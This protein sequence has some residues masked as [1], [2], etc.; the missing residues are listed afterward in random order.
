MKFFSGDN[1]AAVVAEVATV[2]HDV[3]AVGDEHSVFR[4]ILYRKIFECNIFH[5]SSA[6]WPEHNSF[7]AG[8]VHVHAVA[9]V[10]VRVAIFDGI[11][12]AL[13]DH[14]DYV[15]IITFL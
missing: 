13:D 11:C 9:T 7:A 15:K 3:I 8:R 12:R 10:G 14:S 2:D 5:R 1:T 6:T 4:I